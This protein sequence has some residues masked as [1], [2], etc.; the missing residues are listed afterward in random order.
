[1]QLQPGKREEEAATCGVSSQ[2]VGHAA[3]LDQSAER[4][5]QAQRWVT[6]SAACVSLWRQIQSGTTRDRQRLAPPKAGWGEAENKGQDKKF[7]WNSAHD[8]NT[9]SIEA[10]ITINKFYP[11]TDHSC[12]AFSVEA[13][14]VIEKN[15]MSLVSS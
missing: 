7:Y 1:M 8:C 5:K 14:N 9:L 3:T 6:G 10:E 4:W 2:S 11:N 13:E 15:N 12:K